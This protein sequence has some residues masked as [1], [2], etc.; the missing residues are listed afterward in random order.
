MPERG[1]CRAVAVVG[2]DIDAAAVVD[3]GSR[4]NRLR[5]NYIHRSVGKLTTP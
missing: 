1:L 2:G 5:K 3:K 4:R